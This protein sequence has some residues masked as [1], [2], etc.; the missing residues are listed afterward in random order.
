MEVQCSHN[1]SMIRKPFKFQNFWVK[2][3]EFMEVVE[4]HWVTD[5]VR[6]P[7]HKKLKKVKGAL[8]KWSKEAY[9]NIFQKIN[10]L[11]D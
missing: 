7:F 3:E 9:E 5:F 11:E 2:H 8:E 4:K 6:N 1:N 10:T